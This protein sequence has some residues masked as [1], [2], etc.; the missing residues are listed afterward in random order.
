MITYEKLTNAV[1]F[2]KNQFNKDDMSVSSNDKAVFRNTA[3][4]Y[5]DIANDPINEKRKHLWKNCNDKKMSRPPVMIYQLPWPEIKL[6]MPLETNEPF[7]IQMFRQMQQEIWQWENCPVDMVVEKVFKI[8]K[9][10]TD[11]GFGLETMGQSIDQGTGISS[12]HFTPQITKPEDVNK[13]RPPKV[14]HDEAETQRRMDIMTELVGEILELQAVGQS[15]YWFYCFAPWDTLSIWCNPTTMFMDLML[16]PQMLKDAHQRLVEARISRYEQYEQMGLLE[17][18]DCN[19][20]L[21]PGGYGYTD[22]L[23]SEDFNG[24]VRPKDQWC[25]CAAQMFTGISPEMFDEFA[26]SK[27]L[28]YMNRFGKTYYGCCEGLHDKIEILRK[29]PNLKKIS[30]S[31]WADLGQAVENGVGDYVVSLKPNPAIF[32][33]SDW[34]LETA[35][36]DL[37]KSIDSLGGCHFEIVLKDL[38]TVRNEPFRLTEW[39]QMAMKLVES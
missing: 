5:R 28:Q 11:N 1:W 19:G 35:K 27:E 32:A 24:I 14:T 2:R 6:P 18:N 34:S 3:S 36:N 25:F 10:V 15:D 30:M 26:V 13:I 9:A 31:P 29:I 12:T 8:P 37:K 21:T 39:A 23:P 4:R 16:K 22:D 7:L 17:R 20:W 38:S 33:E